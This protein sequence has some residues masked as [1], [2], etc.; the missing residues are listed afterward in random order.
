MT[1]AS[2]F[3][4]GA[5]LL[6]LAFFTLLPLAP[7]HAALRRDTVTS[8]PE[9]DCDRLAQPPRDVMGEQAITDGGGV[10]V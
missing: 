6:L 3:P 8:V 4:A 7:A 1:H 2:C 10:S 5:R 9:Q